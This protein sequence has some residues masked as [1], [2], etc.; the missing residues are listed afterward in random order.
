M[1]KLPRSSPSK[2]VRLE[3][4]LACGARHHSSIHDACREGEITKTLHISRSARV[5]QT[6][7][8]LATA[9][10]RIF[11]KFGGW[12]ETRALVDQGSETSIL[13]ERLAQKL[14]LPRSSA[15]V[16]VF[17][18]GGNKTAVA[19]DRVVLSFLLRTG[20][21]PIT[22]TTLVLSRLTIYAGG[23]DAGKGEW[24][25]IQ[26]LELADPEYGAEDPIDI[27]LGADAYAIIIQREFRKENVREPIAQ[28]TTLG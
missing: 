2:R 25:H 9:S 5:T 26:G 18:I 10:V 19:K 24:A 23:I 20:G 22:V 1:F 15:S 17:G 8:L 12:H 27:L 28:E 21:R 11:D 13:S 16:T 3:K 14:R 4:E 6:A 7:V